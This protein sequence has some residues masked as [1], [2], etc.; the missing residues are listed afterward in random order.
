MIALV[1]GIAE[2]YVLGWV[3]G[4]DR[5]CRDAEFM[6]GRKV[7]PYWRWCWAVFTPLIMTAILIYFLAT[8]TPLTY[9]DVTYPTW[10]Y[11][12]HICNSCVK[13]TLILID[14]CFSYWLDHYLFWCPTN[15]DMDSSSC[16]Q[17]LRFYVVG[18]VP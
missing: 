6:M 12:K 15:T 4:V 3:Y 13:L 1:L 9:N 14:I 18:E 7:G 17:G 16:H 8:Y 10:A 5:L 2:L 11:G